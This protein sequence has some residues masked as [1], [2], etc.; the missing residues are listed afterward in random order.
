MRELAAAYQR[1]YQHGL[2][3]NEY[4]KQ[5][6]GNKRPRTST[7]TSTTN[8]PMDDTIGDSLD[9]GDIDWGSFNTQMDRPVFILGSASSSM[10]ICRGNSI[11]WRLS[12]GNS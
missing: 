5:H 3:W 8:A 6:G 4:I 7:T 9:L 12:Y 1:D 2:G 11:K 10:D